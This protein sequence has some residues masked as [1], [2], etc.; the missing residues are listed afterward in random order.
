[1]LT[2]IA[3]IIKDRPITRY[4]SG[5]TVRPAT[6]TDALQVARELR[7]EDVNEMRAI[8]GPDAAMSVVLQRHV[9]EADLSFTVC[10]DEHPVAIFGTKQILPNVSAIGLLS[11]PM[12]KEI[13]YTLCRHS[14]HWVDKL[15]LNN[16]LLLNIVHCDNSVHIQWLSWLGFTFVNKLEGFGANGEDFYEFSKL[17]INN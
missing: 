4:G 16:D 6:Q 7:V 1:M 15:H 12:I 13:K 9:M 2:A 11:S 10:K 8:M 5:V 14:K 3:D 17:K